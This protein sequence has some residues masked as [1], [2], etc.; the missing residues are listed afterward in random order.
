[1]KDPL[2]PAMLDE[3]REALLAL[4]AGFVRGEAQVDPREFPKTCEYCPLPGLCRVTESQTAAMH[5]E[6]E[7]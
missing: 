3:W 4:A 5:D 6:A 7:R 2:L 1:M